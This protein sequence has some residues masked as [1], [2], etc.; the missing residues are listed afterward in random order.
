M[1]P[2]SSGWGFFMRKRYKYE[3]ENCHAPDC[4]RQA[5]E[6]FLCDKHYKRL[7]RHGNLK[8]KKALTTD[9]RR[10]NRIKNIFNYRSKKFFGGLRET[11]FKRDNYSC[12]DC[13][14]TMK[15]HKDRWKRE[16]TINHIDGN[17]RNSQSPNNQLSNLETLCLICHS[18]KD[19]PRIWA[20]R[21]VKQ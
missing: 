8:I 1:K 7:R 17:G 9:E 14:M 16:L 20:E 12:I 10:I 15:E 11:V 5:I 21:R 4:K 3:G 19:V 13:G 6:K 2:Q 18:K